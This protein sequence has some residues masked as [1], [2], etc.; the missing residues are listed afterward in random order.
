MVALGACLV[1]E[2]QWVVWAAVL[3]TSFLLVSR[4]KFVHFGRVILRRIPRT[5]VVFMGFVAVFLIA[6]LIKARDSGMLGALLLTCFSIYLITN[7]RIT[8][9]KG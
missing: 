1:W 6:Y 8:L 2:N 5:F 7:S 3:V 4:I 9:I